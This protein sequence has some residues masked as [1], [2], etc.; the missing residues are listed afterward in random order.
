[1][2]V[3]RSL[4][5]GA[6]LASGFLFISTP[7]YAT[8]NVLR[9]RVRQHCKAHYVRTTKVFKVHG[10]RMRRR[11]CVRL[12]S[13]MKSPSSRTPELHFAFVNPEGWEYSGSVPIP[14]RA[15][16]FTVNVA[17]SPPGYARPEITLTG[18]PVEKYEFHDTNPGRPGGPIV[19]AGFADAVYEIPN[20]YEARYEGGAAAP[21]LQ[22][23][24]PC[25]DG[26][27]NG[28]PD[29]QPY[30]YAYGLECDLEGPPINYALGPNGREQ[31]VRT[32]VKSLS[33]TN[34]WYAFEINPPSLQCRI[35]V[36]MTGSVVYG[37]E[38]GADDKGESCESVRTTVRTG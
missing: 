4:I 14:N 7:A 21:T 35:Y 38:Y 15:I 17:S 6:T 31:E 13:A 27:N 3:H 11:V 9:H 33:D 26:G 23:S 36:S 34:S 37:P 32:F 18:P 16:T 25:S 30:P 5:L 12:L 19:T 29:G 24:T 10:H 1:M 28:Y 2:A 22:E 20:G 8:P